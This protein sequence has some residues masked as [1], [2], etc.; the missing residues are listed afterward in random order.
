MRNKANLTEAEYQEL[1]ALEYVLTWRYTNQ[2]EEDTKRYIE[3]VEKLW[4]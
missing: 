1:L 3:L 4:K 2:Y